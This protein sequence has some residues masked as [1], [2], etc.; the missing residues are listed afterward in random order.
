MH[1]VFNETMGSYSPIPE[2]KLDLFD[3]SQESVVD[4]SD[5][6]P[7]LS[8][9]SSQGLLSAQGK[10]LYHFQD[11]KD[12]GSAIM[13]NLNLDMTE[14]DFIRQQYEKQ[15]KKSQED[16]QNANYEIEN[17]KNQLTDSLS[18]QISNPTQSAQ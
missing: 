5:W 17:L 11:G 10:P 6:S 16:L 13:L 4:F 9:I 7:N 12:D 18:S 15:L 3:S 8:T 14:L 1:Y 2:T